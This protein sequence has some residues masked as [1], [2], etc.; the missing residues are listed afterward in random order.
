MQSAVRCLKA[1][2]ERF[3]EWDPEMDSIVACGSARYDRERDRQVPIIYGDYFL[4]EGM[5]RLLDRDFL[6]W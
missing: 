1:V 5:L 4:V 6:I 2:T 3:C